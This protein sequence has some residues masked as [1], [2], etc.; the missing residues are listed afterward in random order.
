MRIFLVVLLFWANS[1]SGQDSLLME[2]RQN[3]GEVFKT[4]SV[5]LN[6]KEAFDRTDISNNNLLLGYKGAIELGMARHHPN[7][8]KK[9]GYFG[10][11]K[12]CLEKS[13]TISPES[14]EL[15]FLRLTIQTN[16]PTFLGY[17]DDIE[18]DK[19]FVLSHLKYAPSDEFKKRA[20][21]FIKHAEEQG[22]L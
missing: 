3:I 9:M 1:A 18:K 2:I 7:L 4:E 19:A 15:R 22:K 16:L 6:F 17:S 20:S 5:C 10:D 11:G 8:I 12:E 13:I 14:I 21:N